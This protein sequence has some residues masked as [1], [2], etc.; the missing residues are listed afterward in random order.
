MPED[1]HSINWTVIHIMSTKY[2]EWPVSKLKD[3]YQELEQKLADLNTKLCD[4]CLISC[5]FQYCNECDLMFNPL[6][7]ILHLIDE[8]PKPEEKAELIVEDMPFQEPNETTKTEQYLAYPDLFKELELKWYSNNEERICPKKAHDTD[9]GFNLQ[10]SRQSPI[11]IAPHSLKRINVKGGIIDAGYTENIII[12]LQNNLDRSYKI[13]SQEKIAQAIFL[14][15]VSLPEEST[16]LDQMEEEM[17]QSTSWRKTVN[18]K[19]QD[20]ALLFKANPEICSLAN[21]VNLYLLAKAHKHFK[22]P[23]YN[24]TEDVIEIPKGT[25]ISSISL[26]IQHPEKLH[27]LFTPEEINKLNLGNLSTLQQ[28]QLK[29]LLNQYANVFASKNEFR[30]TDIVKHQIDTENT[31]PIK[32]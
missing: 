12:M 19:I 24:L 20:Q 29:V 8:L 32:Q 22:I 7:R 25:L 26:N 17:Y 16:G 11:I 30:H 31:Q 3:H 14:S 21:V 1:E 10:Y 27:Y 9:T 28:M 23:I 18:R 13:K 5:H 15:L 4:H 6:P 2:G